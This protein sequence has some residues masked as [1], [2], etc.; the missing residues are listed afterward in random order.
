MRGWS[1]LAYAR[2]Q[3]GVTQQA[4]AEAVGISVKTL[5]RLETNWPNANPRIRLLVN[6]SIALAVPLEAL[7]DPTWLS[8]SPVGE[9]S[10]PPGDKFRDPG[11]LNIPRR[12]AEETNLPTDVHVVLPPLESVGMPD[13]PDEGI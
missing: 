13:V 5:N 3:A 2:V 10:E 9:K 12:V 6:L 4:L 7:Y 8:W 11:R 1:R